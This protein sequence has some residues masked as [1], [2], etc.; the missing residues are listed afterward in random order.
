MASSQLPRPEQG[1]EEGHLWTVSFS[2][3]CVYKR[4]EGA[5]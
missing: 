3:T 4:S 5:P 1:E 2:E